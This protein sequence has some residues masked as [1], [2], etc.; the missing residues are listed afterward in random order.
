MG[1]AG[2]DAV[3]RKPPVRQKYSHRSPPHWLPPNVSLMG[4]SRNCD[5]IKLPPSSTRRKTGRRWAVVTHS[6]EVNLSKPSRAWCVKGVKEAARFHAQAAWLHPPPQPLPESGCHCHPARD[7]R[8]RRHYFFFHQPTSHV[9]WS[10]W[11][12]AYVTTV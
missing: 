12:S 10:E 9:N 11:D 7:N 4:G 1:W 2:I 5:K 8:S 3:Y 6:W